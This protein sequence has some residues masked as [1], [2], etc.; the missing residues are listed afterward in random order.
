MRNLFRKHLNSSDTSLSFIRPSDT[1]ACCWDVRQPA[2]NNNNYPLVKRQAFHSP[3][4]TQTCTHTDMYTHVQS[5]V[6]ALVH[7]YTHKHTCA[8][9]HTRTHAHTH[10]H[11]HTYIHTFTHT[12][13][14][15]HTIKG[16]YMN[17]LFLSLSLI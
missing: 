15:T 3:C 13:T 6:L 17:T 2:N 14:H 4:L 11:T 1:L 8:R 12:H 10:S 7:I 5:R 16:N 9:T